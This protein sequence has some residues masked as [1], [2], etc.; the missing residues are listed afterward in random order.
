MSFSKIKKTYKLLILGI[1]LSYISV[2]QDIQFS[3]FYAVPQFYNPA[4]AGGAHGLRAML[5]GRYQ[6]PGLEAR[7]VTGLVSVDTYLP[8]YKSGIGGF[9][10]YDLQGNNNYNTHLFALQYSYE[11]MLNKKYTFR[12]GL[13][14]AFGYMTI[15]NN[16]TFPN[17]FNNDGPNGAAGESG[18]RASVPYFD[19]SAGG[20]LYGKYLW[21]GFG[22]HHL[23]RPN[24]TFLTTNDGR[25]P[26][27]VTIHAGY[28]IPLA[29]LKYMKY[30]ESEKDISIS[31]TFQ[32]KFQTGGTGGFGG[33]N[34]QLDIGL[35]GIYDVIYLGVWYRGI[36]FKQYTWNNKL[37]NNES[38]SVMIG[39]KFESANVYAS[40]SYDAVISNLAGYAKGAHEL[41]ITYILPHKSKKH[42]IW[43]M[44]PC[45][46]FQ[47][48]II[49]NEAK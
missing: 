38:I 25:L 45:P 34:M 43:K 4:F 35:Y 7:Y 42:K 41:N 9:Y 1:F 29:H 26:L 48:D 10:A 32:Y 3:Q 15:G 36:A 8:R 22:V 11:V 6:W 24:L 30:M 33:T 46:T 21:A 5:H 47:L 17:Q 39:Y 40:Y 44:L 12:F 18:I 37:P 19:A 2:S 23:T 31:P 16:F 13:Q 14:P 20:L 27:N 28:K 49:H